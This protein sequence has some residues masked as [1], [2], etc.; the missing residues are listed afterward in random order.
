MFEWINEQVGINKGDILSGTW[1]GFYFLF[2][3]LTT[4]KN[5]SLG[6]PPKNGA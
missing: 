6:G 1:D 2:F 4:E 5:L 3:K